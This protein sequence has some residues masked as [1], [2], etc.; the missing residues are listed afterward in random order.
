MKRFVSMLL[1]S[2]MTFSTFGMVAF[3]DDGQQSASA[4][5]KVET[6][7]V[8]DSKDISTWGDDVYLEEKVF[9]YDPTKGNVDSFYSKHEKYSVATV[10]NVLSALRCAGCWD[11]IEKA[12]LTI[13]NKTFKL[14]DDANYDQYLKAGVAI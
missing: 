9:E 12:T 3:A 4:G 13:G 8:D 14:D 7:S 6:Q 1:A 11:M 2:V 10:E 5:S